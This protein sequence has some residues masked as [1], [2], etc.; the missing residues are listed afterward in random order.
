[1]LLTSDLLD[2]KLTLKLFKKWMQG[3]QDLIP[4]AKKILSIFGRKNSNL[5]VNAVGERK[6]ITR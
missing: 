5:T 1:M 6:F 4:D 3:V 2:P